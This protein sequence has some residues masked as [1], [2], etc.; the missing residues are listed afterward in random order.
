M[1]NQQRTGL[2]YGLTAYTIW[3]FF[4]LYFHWLAHISPLEVLVQRV[5]WSFLLIL[6][7]IF[8]TGGYQR[9]VTAWQS[10][11]TRKAMLL[12]SVLITIN[13]LTFIWAVANEHVLEASFGY[14]LTPLVSVLL[15]KIVLGEQLDRYRII[16][17]V[18]AVIGVLWQ[19]ISLQLLPWVSL[20]VAISFGLYGLVRKRADA[21]AVTGLGIETGLLVPLALIYWGWLQW[22][23]DSQFLSVDMSTTALLIASGVLT[24]LPLML[25]AAAAKKLSLMAVGFMMYINPTIQFLIGVYILKEPFSM[26]Q[27]ISFCFIWSALVIFSMGAV[28]Q[29]RNTKATMRLRPQ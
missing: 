20:T 15:A 4:P 6:G 5:V 24:A 11:T 3:G 16:A 7:I 2:I 1:I 12:S 8:F 19:V 21:D 28:R 9:I 22:R 18:L 29:H 23:G 10:A 27:I 17:C 26:H 14:F 13:W 25:F